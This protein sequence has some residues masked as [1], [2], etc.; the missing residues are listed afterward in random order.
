MNDNLSDKLLEDDDGGQPQESLCSVSKGS[1]VSSAQNSQSYEYEGNFQKELAQKIKTE[2]PAEQN[3][4]KIQQKLMQQN[5]YIPS[6]PKL[7]DMSRI[8]DHQLYEMLSVIP[9]SIY[10]G[11]EIKEI[12]ENC[13]VYEARRYLNELIMLNERNKSRL[14]I[15]SEMSME[16]ASAISKND[17][18]SSVSH[19]SQRNL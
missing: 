14:K 16:D 7:S 8:Q 10:N 2:K 5:S 1:S 12:A 13:S 6:M 3:P 19:G 9:I 15:V 18:S 11:L 17:N 4:V